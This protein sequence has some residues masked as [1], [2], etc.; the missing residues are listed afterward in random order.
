[1]NGI[2]T[3]F[4]ARLGRDAELRMVE[5]GSLPMV[6][7]T[8]AVD[9]Q[10]QTEDN[11]PVWVR[12]VS[13]GDLAETMAERLVKSTRVYIE[14]RLSVDLWQ[15]DD[16]RAPRVNIQVVANILQPLG[17]IGRRLPTRGQRAH[18]R[19][20]DAGRARGAGEAVLREA[21]QPRM[22]DPPA[23]WLDD[24]EAAIRDLVEGPGR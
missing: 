18:D 14:G 7:F 11:P 22:P 4:T 16:G 12:V 1:M 19:S 3:C 8:A 17:Q 21:R 23:S 15:P 24:S 5:D 6:S 20:R 9:Q 2:E 13:F 10:H